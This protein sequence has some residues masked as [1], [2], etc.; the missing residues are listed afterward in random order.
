MKQI[1]I[2][3]RSLL[4]QVSAQARSSPR[5]RKNYNFHVAETDLS[6]R[7]LNAVEPNSYIPPHCHHDLSKDE[8][9]IVLRG[10]LGVVFFDG[11]GNMTN[12]VLLTPDS[13]SMGV[14]IPHGVFHTLVALTSGS[15]FFEAKAGPYVPLTA[16]EKAPWAPTE[17]DPQ[18]VV[19]L[20]RLKQM[21]A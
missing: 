8:T 5:L 14:S 19:Y 18:A 9:I 11:Q 12:K 21:F 6:H 4:D 15:V 17:D 1:Q 20:A 3:Q 2:I 7:L 16:Q 10:R 13:D